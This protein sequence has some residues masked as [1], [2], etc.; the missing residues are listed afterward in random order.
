MTRTILA[1]NNRDWT[2]S[3]AAQDPQVPLDYQLGAGQLNAFRAYQQFSPGQYP[4]S[5]PVPAIGWDYRTVGAGEYRDYPIDRP[6]AAR[7]WVSI[8]LIWDRLVELQDVNGNNRYDLG[9]TF[10]DRGLNHLDLYLMPANEDRIDRSIWSSTSSIDS[11]QHIFH[12]IRDPGKYK[13]RVYFRQAV[14]LPQQSYGL[15]WWTVGE[16]EKGIK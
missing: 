12:Q 2:E 6:L 11:V 5:V 3:E 14:N 9:E 15:S 16:G 10:R 7:S 8:S 13:I 1:K 4:P